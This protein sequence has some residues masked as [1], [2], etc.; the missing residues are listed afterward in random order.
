MFDDEHEAVNFRYDVQC[1]I[2]GENLSRKDK[3]VIRDR[4]MNE[5]V[6]DCLLVIGMPGHIKVHF[7][8]DQPEDLFKILEE[9]GTFEM[10]AIEDM[11]EQYE[12]FRAKKKQEKEENN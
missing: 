9:Y 7:H 10:K 5:C 12:A 6:G 4:I 2:K 1:M 11:K 3:N 8:T